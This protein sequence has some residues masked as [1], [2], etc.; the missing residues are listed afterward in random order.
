MVVV[1][2]ADV[3][4]VAVTAR[5]ASSSRAVGRALSRAR[6]SSLSLCAGYGLVVDGMV[7]VVLLILGCG[8]DEKELGCWGGLGCCL[9]ATPRVKRV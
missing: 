7:V 1:A 6:R 4:P 8:L 3:L 2:F 9:G 5:P